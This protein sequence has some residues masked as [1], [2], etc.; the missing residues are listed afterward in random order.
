MHCNKIVFIFT[1]F[2]RLYGDQKSTYMTLSQNLMI[3]L[4]FE[5][6]FNKMNGGPKHAEYML[7][8]V[9]RVY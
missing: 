1:Y 5:D 2:R 6:R 3:C 8:E 7:Y 9:P 4:T